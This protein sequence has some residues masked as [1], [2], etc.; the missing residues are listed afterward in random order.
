MTIVCQNIT[1]LR[2]PLTLGK[3]VLL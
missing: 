1:Q 3:K 2:Y